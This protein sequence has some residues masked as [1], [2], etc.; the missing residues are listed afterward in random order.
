MLGFDGYDRSDSKFQKSF[1]QIIELERNGAP[2]LRL[3]RH[4]HTETF[5]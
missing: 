1:L 2:L 4:Q 3:S 5:Q